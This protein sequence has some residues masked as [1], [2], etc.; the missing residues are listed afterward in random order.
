MVGSSCRMPFKEVTGN[1]NS[2]FMDIKQY[3]AYVE[4]VTGFKVRP[5][6]NPVCKQRCNYSSFIVI[7]SS[8]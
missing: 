8:S 1:I 5:K 7:S 6:A 4:N 2:Q 3:L